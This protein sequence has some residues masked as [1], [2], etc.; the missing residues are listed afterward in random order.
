MARL[1]ISLLA[2]AV[3]KCE[4]SAGDHAEIEVVDGI[5]VPVCTGGIIPSTET[6]DEPMRG[7]MPSAEELAAGHAAAHWLIQRFGGRDYSA[8]A[9]WDGNAVY[10][11]DLGMI[12][13][14]LFTFGDRPGEERY[15][16]AGHSL[17]RYLQEQLGD[18]RALMSIGPGPSS[19]SRTS[20]WSTEGSAH[21]L[22]VVQCLLLADSMGHAD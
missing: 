12:A 19:T 8:R 5:A 9:N 15:I 14:G 13:R 10:N 11:F 22:K 3:A 1:D 18:G 7:G 4:Q 6:L 17:V 2:G 20:G 21:L 16:E